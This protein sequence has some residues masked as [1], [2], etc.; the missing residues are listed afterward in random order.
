MSLGFFRIPSPAVPVGAW[1]V[2]TYTGAGSL[3]SA[4]GFEWC[5]RAWQLGVGDLGGGVPGFGSSAFRGYGIW[6]CEALVRV[7]GLGFVKWESCYIDIVRE[8]RK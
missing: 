5:G 6:N 2:T 7:W 4:V 1:T 8:G 3:S